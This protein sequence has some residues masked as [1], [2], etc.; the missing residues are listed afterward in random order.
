M[1]T[2]VVFVV[3][4]INEDAILGMPFLVTHNCSIE[5]HQPVIQVD[6]RK[7][8]CMDRQGRLLISSV[9]VIRELVVPRIDDSLDALSRSKFFST[10]D[11]IGAYWQVL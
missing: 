11:L 7:L 4:R 9:Q 2:E 10:L 8:K 6:G 5:F 1:K 3:S